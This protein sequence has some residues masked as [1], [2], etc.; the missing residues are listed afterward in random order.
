MYLSPH[1]IDLIHNLL[2]KKIEVCGFILLDVNNQYYLYC[3]SVMNKIPLLGDCNNI[4]DIEYKKNERPYCSW[5][6]I[7]HPN[8]WHTHPAGSKGYPS[9]EDIT[10]ILKLKHAKIKTSVIFTTWGRWTLSAE[11]RYNIKPQQYTNIQKIGHDLYYKTNNGRKYNQYYVNKYI[12]TLML[13]LSRWKFRI[14]FEE[15]ENGE[16]F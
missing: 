10:K 16:N 7:N 11:N 14:T 8:I 1:N 4:P 9:T 15:W 12:K 6:K 5:T 3:D 13:Y 2:K